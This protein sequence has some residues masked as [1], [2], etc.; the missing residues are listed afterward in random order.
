M[1]RQ[2]TRPTRD[3]PPDAVPAR[4]RRPIG[5]AV[6]LVAAAVFVVCTIGPPLAGRGVFLSHD[7]IYRAY[8]WRALEDPVSL[9][10]ADHGQTSDTVDATFPAR[11]HFGTRVRAGHFDGW[12]PW[13]SGGE[14]FGSTSSAGMLG[15]LAAP[16]LVFPDWLAPA[17]VKLGGL[18]AAIGF[19][20]LFC[21]RLATDRLPALFAGIAFAGSGFMVM[22]TNW[23]HV[24]VAALIPA[25]FWAT[26]RFLQRRTA[27]A[28]VPIAVALAAMLL[29]SF[30]AVT[31]YALYALGAYVVVRLLAEPG[32]DWRRVLRGAAGAGSG[33]LAGLLLVAFVVLPFAARLGEMI[34]ENRAQHPSDNLGVATLLTSVAPE[35]FGLSSNG[36]TFQSKQ[37][38]IYGFAALSQVEAIAFVG[39]STVLLAT[40]AMA[41]PGLGSTPKGARAALAGTTAVVA[42]VMFVGGPAL[43][44]LQIL[45]VFSDNFIGRARS[46]LGFAIAALAALG[47]QAL[48]DQERPLTSSSRRRGALVVLAAVAV[49]AVVLIASV[50]LVRPLGR[51]SILGEGLVL[52]TI[53]GVLSLGAILLLWRGRDRARTVAAAALPCLLVVESLALALPLLPNESSET[54]YPKTEATRFLQDNVGHERVGVEGRTYYGNSPMFYGFRTPTGHAFHAE[55]WKDML[56]AADDQVFASSP[57]FSALRGDPEVVTSPVLD[58]LGV[59]W[60]ATTPERPPFGQR[61]PVSLARG[62]C[63]ESAVRL[64]GDRPASVTVPAGD[65]LRGVVLHLCEPATPTGDATLTLTSATPDRPA[66]GSLHLG[67][68][69]A[70]GELVVA[71]P[72]EDLRS[73][74]EVLQLSLSGA[75]GL[76]LSLAGVEAGQPAV[77]V[78]RPVDDGLRLAFAD[79]LRIYE[80]TSALPRIRW[81]AQARIVPD[82]DERVALLA[83]G[84]VPDDTVVLN[85]DGARADGDPAAVEIVTDEPD[86]ITAR[87]DAE[88]AGYLVVADALQTDWIATVDG[89]S[90]EL[91]D[92][93]HAGVAVAVPA[94]AHDVTLRYR[95]RGQRA[96]LAI[97][98]V[99]ALGLAALVGVSRRGVW[100]RDRPGPHPARHD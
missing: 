100:R 21:R 38:L 55:T 46:I 51:G 57:S 75:P 12:N 5:L 24:D 96:G 47:W 94:G 66:T 19:T 30:P 20:Y 25:L 77:D 99:T 68:P 64:A 67:P 90:A 80:R 59:G 52:P 2:A 35:A 15:P 87:V 28:C 88:G 69:L 32:R 58:R 91:V 49:A 79:E 10:V 44:E 14:P 16:F 27:A 36:E 3:A 71:I 7:L 17:L 72:G 54:L 22:W 40:A 76:E 6:G 8:P 50:R 61:A 78:I 97:S 93:D 65:G 98:G 48:V 73:G 60:F 86:G 9:N 29:G 13:V 62:T 26:E 63:G 70:E 74:G 89:E 4:R 42:W 1:A 37:S 82:S 45:P 33:L 85:E 84:A 92:A 53:I 34:G 31:G 18:I 41:L 95:P 39:V 11:S 43:R 81:A 83:G 56:V 23:Q